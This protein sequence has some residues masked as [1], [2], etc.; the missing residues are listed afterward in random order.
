M[1]P[2]SVVLPLSATSPL[3]SSWRLFI[4]LTH[5]SAIFSEASAKVKY[6]TV[7]E[8]G[9]VSLVLHPSCREEGFDRGYKVRESQYLLQKEV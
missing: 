7:P 1:F 2:I 6:H 8:Q 9:F 5:S 3:S 4:A